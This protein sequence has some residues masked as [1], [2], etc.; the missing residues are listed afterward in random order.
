MT[1]FFEKDKLSWEKCVGKL[2]FSK[3]EALKDSK[4]N[5]RLS[6][7]TF[8]SMRMTSGIDSGLKVK[9]MINCFP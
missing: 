4:R 8:G 7:K 3:S 2:A 1:S 6:G 5:P 9:G